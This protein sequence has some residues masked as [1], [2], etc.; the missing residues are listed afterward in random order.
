M[1]NG[2]QSY[3][4]MTVDLEEWNHGLRID[5]RGEPQV[6]AD[7]GW[8]LDL[9]A[10]LGVRSTFFV[11]SQVVRDH[12]GLVRRLVEAGHEVGFHGHYH[13]FLVNVGPERFQESLR[14]WVPRLEDLVQRPIEGF[15][16]PFFSIGP[17][18]AWALPMLEEAGFRYDASIYP[19]PNDRYGWPDAP[20]QPAR[21]AGSELVLF[22]VPMLHGSLPIAFSGGAYLRMLPLWAVRW[23]LKRQFARGQS[24]MIY[25]HPW[26][27][28]ETLPRPKDAHWRAS[29]TRYPGRRFMRP[30]LRRLLSA[31]RQRVRPMGEIVKSLDTI[32]EW[33]PLH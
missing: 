17:K 1:M 18:S 9:F 23:G 7:T 30:R 26:E 10:E 24:G 20:K 21:L 6:E 32:P 27:V 8:L 3:V 14:E 12:P 13:D 11:L 25:V 16:A 4:A 31:E 28:A 29:L 15:R 5:M 33:Q 22:P 2:A 19:G